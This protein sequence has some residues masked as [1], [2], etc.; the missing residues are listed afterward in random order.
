MVITWWRLLRHSSLSGSVWPRRLSFA[1]VVLRDG[2]LFTAINF[3]ACLQRS[4]D[5][6]L[7]VRIILRSAITSAI[8]NRTSFSLIVMLNTLHLVFTVDSVRPQEVPQPFAVSPG[9]R[10]DLDKQLREQHDP[11]H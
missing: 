6:L 3:L 1:N 4:R 11:L 8:S 10:P 5:D 2:E 7:H 9:P